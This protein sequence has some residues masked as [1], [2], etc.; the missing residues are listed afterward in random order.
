MEIE[1]FNNNSNKPSD[2]ESLKQCAF[3]NLQK[4]GF[5]EKDI[6]KIQSSKNYIRLV[7]TNADK[8]Y[9]RIIESIPYLQSLGYNQ[10]QIIHMVQNTPSVV[11]YNKENIELIFQHFC[12]LGFSQ[13]D[14]VKITSY[15]PH[16]LNKTTNEI[17]LQFQLYEQKGFKKED[18]AH[19]IKGFPMALG[20]TQNKLESILNILESH[21]L[22]NDIIIKIIKKHPA[23]LCY[24]PE[25]LNKKIRCI[26]EHNID[27]QFLVDIPY[28]LLLP[29]KKLLE[30][31]NFLKDIGVDISRKENL[32]ILNQ[33]V[34]VIYSKY[35]L[36]AKNRKKLTPE[37]VELLKG[38]SIYAKYDISAIDLIKKYPYNRN[39]GKSNNEEEIE[40]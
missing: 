12:Q 9:T 10:S 2:T 14:T 11:L 19:I 18:V 25:V 21:G 17:D 30:R 33:N 37:E 20:T 35:K 22:N 28:L 13:E 24:S 3:E 8:V 5:K 34:D 16:I 4:N 29:E 26:T 38:K 36:L 23:L 6:Q 7:G 40:K 1:E 31:L 15:M 32:N 39:N 27:T